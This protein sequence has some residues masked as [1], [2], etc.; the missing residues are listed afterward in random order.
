MGRIALWLL[1]ILV[2]GTNSTRDATS[3]EL[4]VGRNQHPLQSLELIQPQ[5][6]L[7]SRPSLYW[8][9][10]LLPLMITLLLLMI[11]IKMLAKN[12]LR[13]TNKSMPI[14]NT[15]RDLGTKNSSS[16][17]ENNFPIFPQCPWQPGDCYSLMLSITLK[18]Y[19]KLH[20]GLLKRKWCSKS[21]ERKLNV[22]PVVLS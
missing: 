22:K 10:S 15:A 3:G 11:F 7:R 4:G 21:K 16:Y 18:V 5:A 17:C 6:K 19:L 14:N 9:L 20:A 8:N 13:N 12:Y 1:C 2:G